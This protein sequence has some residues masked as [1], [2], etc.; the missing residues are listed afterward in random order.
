MQKAAIRDGPNPTAVCGLESQPSPWPLWSCL[1]AGAAKGL[2]HPYL[3]FW[4]S[5]E[6][7][8]SH[9]LQGCFGVPLLLGPCWLQLPSIWPLPRKDFT[10]FAD[11]WQTLENIIGV[12]TGDGQGEQILPHT[13]LSC[14][15]GSAETSR[16]PHGHG[17]GL[18]CA[19]DPVN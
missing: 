2:E 5:Q 19:Y 1:Q 14:G 12:N 13:G 15:C 8:D 7:A 17:M 11:F 10:N 4:E 6:A 18:S 9:P 3:P 16:A